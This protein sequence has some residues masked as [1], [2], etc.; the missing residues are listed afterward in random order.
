M[1]REGDCLCLFCSVL[2]CFLFGVWILLWVGG[3]GVLYF[4][5]ICLSMYFTPR[6]VLPC[7]DPGG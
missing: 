7:L 6:A 1:Y 3:V 4:Y 2:F 5:F